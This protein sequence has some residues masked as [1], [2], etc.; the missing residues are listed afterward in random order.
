MNLTYNSDKIYSNW[1]KECVDFFSKW[2]DSDFYSDKAEHIYFYSDVNDESVSELQ[3]LLK[4]SSKTNNINNVTSPPKPIVI[5]LNSPGGSVLSMN[6]FNVMILTLRVPLCVIIENTCASAATVLALIAPYRLMIDYSTYL[7]HDMAGISYGKI[8]ETIASDFS[9]IYQ[10]KSN[11]LSL[12][13]DRTN[14]SDAEIKKFISR[15]MYINSSYCLKKKIIDRVLKFPKIKNSSN[16]DRSVYSDLSLNLPTF[17]KK[18]N[19]NHLYIDSDK[20]YDFSNIGNHENASTILNSNSLSE[21]CIS[22]DKYILCN[23]NSIIK[24]LLIHFKP[25]IMKYSNSTDLVSLQ[26][27]I[28][29]I[30]KNTPVVA[31]IE[32]PQ[33]LGNL[34]LILMCP[35]RIM[36]TPS[37]ISSYFTSKWG[38]SMGWGWKTIDVL[39]NTKY[40]L[41]EVIKFFKNFSKLPSKFYNELQH[42]IINLKPKDSLEYE[43]VNQVINFRKITPLTQKDIIDYYNIENLT[44]DY[45]NIKKP[46]TKKLIT[47]KPISRKKI[48]RKKK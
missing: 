6:L 1:V 28:A 7:I 11:Y 47:K 48:S 37:I 38:G 4:K 46:I 32:G 26:Y 18:T 8:N 41:T 22:L 20:I 29:L 44:S 31:L 9:F 23:K 25:D 15:D 5:H 19:L 13:K 34:S 35:I 16:Y 39:Y 2:K 33:S 24:P 30:Q 14:L 43:I 40:I 45:K 3:N 12:L 42:K 17:L 21:I 36:M 27:R 10:F